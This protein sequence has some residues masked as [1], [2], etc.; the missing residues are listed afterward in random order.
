MTNKLVILEFNDELDAFLAQ[1]KVNSRNIKDYTVICLQPSVRTRCKETVPELEVLD[2]L[3][4]FDNDSHC[5]ALETSNRLTGLFS[6]AFPRDIETLVPETLADTFIYY[7]RF[8]LNNYLRILE[9]LRGIYAQH[10]EAEIYVVEPPSGKK[11]A[12]NSINPFLVNRDRFV[13]FL[14]RDYCEGRSLTFRSLPSLEK[15]SSPSVSAEVSGFLRSAARWLLQRRLQRMQG[16]K[17]V[18]LAAL[19]YNFDRL[20]ADI[21]LRKPEMRAVT[22]HESAM[23]SVGYLKYSIKEILR[24][25]VPFKRRNPVESVQIEVM[26]PMGAG[27]GVILEMLRGGFSQFIGQQAVE[28]QYEG[29][30]IRD[31]LAQKVERDLLPH[32]AELQRT[33]AAQQAILAALRPGILLSPVSIGPFQAWGELCKQVGI[34]AVVI[35]QKGLV[36]PRD[37]FA[38][39]EEYYIGRAQVTE[40]FQ[41]AVA[42]TPYVRDYL[43]LA[44]YRGTIIESGNLI[45]SKRLRTIGRD[46][47]EGEE[48][49]QRLGISN[50]SFVIVYA[51]SMKSRKSHRFYVLETLDELLQSIGDVIRVVSSMSDVHLVL[52]IHPGEPI[53]RREI[54]SL[55]P[56]PMNV[57][58]SDWGTFEEILSIADLTI[59]FSSTSIQESLINGVP[60]VLYDRWQRYNHL[61]AAHIETQEQTAPLST[62]YITTQDHLKHIIRE[63]IKQK[64]KSAPDIGI[65]LADI[66]PGRY[67]ENFYKLL[68]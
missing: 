48:L 67:T 60:V 26:M 54:E 6:G 16:K 29:V 57:S 68:N 37:R 15:E 43:T 64:K 38:Q 32:L 35:P 25:L 27:D 66:F 23:S 2:T 51:P 53:T 14:V 50:D 56:M 5:R 52:R 46:S 61:D 39:M 8:Y 19:S 9:I 3:P 31:V 65:F 42:Q 7:V 55:L 21:L 40:S 30:S 58:I 10:K 24:L 20:F 41:Y 17:V 45:F 63:I 12:K 13:Y 33:A 62:Y 28:F 34:P 1:L 49:R 59:S 36:A 22:V 44:E 4:F 11:N 18:F 47:L